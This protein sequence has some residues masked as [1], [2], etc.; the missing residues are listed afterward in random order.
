MI[1]WRVNNNEIIQQDSPDVEKISP[2][3]IVGQTRV[4]VDVSPTLP[5]PVRRVASFQKVS[6]VHSP[7][8]V[9]RTCQYNRQH[10]YKHSRIIGL[11][12]DCFDLLS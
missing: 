5:G 11:L 1:L 12:F 8:L 7:N 9:I 10:K 4:W 3:F 6:V 2:T